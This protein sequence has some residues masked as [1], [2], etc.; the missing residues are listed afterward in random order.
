MQ[1][2]Q[3][4]ILGETDEANMTLL[5]NGTVPQNRHEVTHL[6]KFWGFSGTLANLVK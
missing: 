5:K 6:Y 3:N 2:G 4:G 1:T